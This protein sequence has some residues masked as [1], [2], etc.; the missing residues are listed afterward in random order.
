M[1]ACFQCFNV[2]SGSH[3]FFKWEN[4]SLF[5]FL[6]VWL[7]SALLF[8]NRRPSRLFIF[9]LN[10]KTGG[11]LEIFF[12]LIRFIASVNKLLLPSRIPPLFL[13]SSANNITVS[14]WRSIML[15]TCRLQGLWPQWNRIHW[16]AASQG[17]I[18]D[19]LS[20]KCEN[21]DSWG[22][23]RWP[24]PTSHLVGKGGGGA[25]GRR[26]P[27]TSMTRAVKISWIILT[28]NT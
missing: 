19:E 12:F 25:T 28:I 1:K 2:L 20:S 22:L 21:Q 6:P 4:A 14:H 16:W 17:V 9:Q 11:R 8:L 26:H 7:A 13:K 10:M 3:D 23:A 27:C 15:T 5:T 24:W 18:P